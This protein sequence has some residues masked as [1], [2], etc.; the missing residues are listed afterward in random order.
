MVPV[1]GLVV[2]TEDYSSNLVS[3]CQKFVGDTRS[4]RVAPVRSPTVV[5][6][7]RVRTR[8]LWTRTVRFQRSGST[9]GPY[10]AG[11]RRKNPRGLSEGLLELPKC[12]SGIRPRVWPPFVSLSSGDLR[13][14]FPGYVKWGR[15]PGPDPDTEPLR[16]S[17]SKRP[18]FLTSGVLV[19]GGEGS[20]G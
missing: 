1:A 14:G 18:L 17:I 3:V 16:C 9:L 2:Y 8:R 7:R 19:H 15:R 5:R 20:T 11:W 10:G 6:S 12:K 13:P 4:E